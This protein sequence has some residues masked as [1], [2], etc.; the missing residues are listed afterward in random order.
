MIV[1]S[2]GERFLVVD[3]KFDHFPPVSIVYE[4]DSVLA[5]SL[6]CEFEGRLEME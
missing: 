5:M 3:H 2:V 4:Y 1:E 6:R